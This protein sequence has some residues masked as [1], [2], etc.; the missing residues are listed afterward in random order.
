M[1]RPESNEYNPFYAGYIAAIEGENIL[2]ILK[3][4]TSDFKSVLE[5][6]PEDRGDFSY[7]PEKWSIKELLGHIIDAER[8]F[9]YRTLR[10]ARNDNTELAVFDQYIYVNNNNLT[11]RT[12]KSLL[13]E[14]LM[15][16]QSTLSLLENIDEPTS[17]R[18]GVANTFKVTVRALAFITAGHAIHHLKVLKEKY[19]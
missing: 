3:Q 11:N 4:N 6:I 19:L 7:A 17:L 1:K 14:F 18:D 16:R 13:N 10:V 12:I 2:D 5:N 8:I 15:V 9:T